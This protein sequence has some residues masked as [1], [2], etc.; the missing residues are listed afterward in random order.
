MT[1]F[2][3]RESRQV[4]DDAQDAQDAQ[5]FEE[6]EELQS[7]M[8]RLAARAAEHPGWTAADFEAEREAERQ[9]SEE[10]AEEL[11]QWNRGTRRRN[12][13]SARHNLWN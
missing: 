12:A 2:M 6:S 3:E 13:R 10:L 5:G 9:A 1:Q 4:S 7:E 11:H 8:D